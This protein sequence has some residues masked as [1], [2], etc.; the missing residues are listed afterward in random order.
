M[1]VDLLALLMTLAAC[2]GAAVMF[3]IRRRKHEGAEIQAAE[4]HLA[5]NKELYAAWARIYA[6]SHG[7]RE[8]SGVDPRDR[9]LI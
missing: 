6:E 3:T 9:L 2:V 5:E 4:Q 1:I 7:G 8:P